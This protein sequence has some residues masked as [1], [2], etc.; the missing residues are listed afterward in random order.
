[1]AAFLRCDCFFRFSETHGPPL[2][3]LKVVAMP[4]I[5]AARLDIPKPFFLYTG[6]SPPN[7]TSDSFLLLSRGFQQ[8]TSP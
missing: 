1:M 5:S 6:I 2:R 8:I 3:H 4:A 7:A